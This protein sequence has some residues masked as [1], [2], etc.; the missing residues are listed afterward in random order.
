MIKAEKC[1][2]RW[3]AIL[4]APTRIHY[5]QTR[6][7][8]QHTHSLTAHTHLRSVLFNVARLPFL[9]RTEPRCMQNSNIMWIRRCR[10]TIQFERSS[11]IMHKFHFSNFLSGISCHAHGRV[12]EHQLSSW[13]F[14]ISGNLFHSIAKRS[15]PMNIN[16]PQIIWVSWHIGKY[17]IV[18]TFFFPP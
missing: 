1:I 12:Q 9:I 14:L 3:S 10:W 15:T 13:G 17:H 2:Q 5:P 7:H 16:V 18:P 8:K 11:N 4:S 6:T